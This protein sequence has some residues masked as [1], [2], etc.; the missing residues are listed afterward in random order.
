MSFCDR[1]AVIT[2]VACALAKQ[3]D[4]QTLEQLPADLVQLGDTLAAMHIGKERSKYVLRKQKS[5]NNMNRVEI[6]FQ[7]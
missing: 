7:M 4:A 5:K 2:A 1:A 3:L 6:S